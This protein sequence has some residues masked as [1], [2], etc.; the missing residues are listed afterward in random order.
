MP[1]PKNDLLFITELADQRQAID[2]L[3][4]ESRASGDYY[5][6]LI[7]SG[8]IACLGLLNNNPVIIIGAMLIAP[9]LFPIL[10]LGMAVVTASKS[11]TWRAIKVI[12]ISTI[13]VVLTSTFLTFMFQ[14]M[15]GE[16][17]NESMVLASSPNLSSIMVALI[18]G[19][20]ASYAWVKQSQSALLPGVAIAVSLVPPLANI[21]IGITAGSAAIFSGSLLT[22]VLNLVAIT[23]TSSFIFSLFGF[24]E[25]RNWQSKRLEQEALEAKQKHEKFVNTVETLDEDSNAI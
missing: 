4:H 9:A 6:Y 24:S 14:F 1:A 8:F 18:S 23:L 25:L 19:L 21:G 2:A 5:F 12:A 22:F 13:S 11:A 10:S 16:A 3:I 7:M 17:P 15:L 20:I